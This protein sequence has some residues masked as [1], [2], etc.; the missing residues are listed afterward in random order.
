MYPPPDTSAKHSIGP[1]NGN[2]LSGPIPYAQV[3]CS[4]E[5]RFVGL[6]AR[7]EDGWDVPERLDELADLG[8]C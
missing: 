5:I 6:R 4:V 1:D 7:G 2:P 3:E 8:L